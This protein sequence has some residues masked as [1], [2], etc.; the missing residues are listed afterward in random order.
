M[1]ALGNAAFNVASGSF[2]GS[3]FTSGT[4]PIIIVACPVVP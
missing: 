3:T 1:D 4:E 2:G